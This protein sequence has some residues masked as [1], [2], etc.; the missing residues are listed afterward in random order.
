[1][2]KPNKANNTFIDG[3]GQK[4]PK[5]RKIGMTIKA[6][7]PFDEDDLECHDNKKEISPAVN[8]ERFLE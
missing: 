1:L 7:F 5:L 2:R 4:Q 3:C 6:E 8:A